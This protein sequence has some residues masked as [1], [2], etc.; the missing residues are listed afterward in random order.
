MD[1]PIKSPTILSLC[2]G[3]RGLERGIERA[4][5]EI[6]TEIILE[7]EAFVIENLVQQME[8]G[9]LAPSLIF[10]DIKSFDPRPFAGRI[11]GITG[12][13]PCQPFSIA[14]KQLGKEDPRHLWPYIGKGENSIV[15]TIRPL[16]AFFENV[17]GLLELGYREVKQDLESL[18]YKVEEGIFSAEEVGAPHQRKR[19]FILAVRRD[20]LTTLDN[21]YRKRWDDE[22]KRF[23][24]TDIDEERNLEVCGRE[25]SNK[26]CGTFE[27]STSRIELAD[28]YYQWQPQPKRSIKEI[29]ERAFNGSEQL[30]NSKSL[31]VQGRKGGQGQIESWRT[32]DGEDE[33][34][35]PEHNE[36][37]NRESLVE[38]S[39]R[40]KTRQ[41]DAIEF[42]GSGE[43]MANTCQFN[44]QRIERRSTDT[45]ERTESGER[46]IGSQSIRDRWPARPGQPQFEWEEPRVE[47]RLG[48]SVDGYNYREDLLRMAGNAVVPQQAELAWI[49]LWNKIYERTPSLD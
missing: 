22:Q 20:W 29:G 37:Q 4:I 35:N 10:T 49:T 18:G 45:Q 47:S 1:N 39:D 24:K 46:Q 23:V 36:P 12:G 8:Q 27:P 48:F 9:I 15:G 5:G 31:H 17:T 34:G 33:L 42:E 32:G 21:T 43:L 40:D 30:G 41:N 7:I 14:G 38:G 25:W 44:V 26:Q 16:W 28:C 2:T 3:M 11:D 19:L 6:R 13:F